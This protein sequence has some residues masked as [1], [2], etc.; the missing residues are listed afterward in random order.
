MSRA[1]PW[2]VGATRA[3]QNVLYVTST[4]PGRELT[5]SPPCSLD[6]LLTGLTSAAMTDDDWE[7]CAGTLSAEQVLEIEN[8]FLLFSKGKGPSKF[9]ETMHLATVIRALG[10][11]GMTEAGTCV[12]QSNPALLHTHVHKRPHTPSL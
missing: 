8:V 3:S 2:S 9:I 4:V 5:P 1:L 11:V 10:D 6:A 7:E 12:F